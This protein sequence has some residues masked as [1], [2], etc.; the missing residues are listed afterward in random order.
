[1]ACH[2]DMPVLAVPDNYVKSPACIV[3]CMPARAILELVSCSSQLA[4]HVQMM[5]SIAEMPML[6]L[7]AYLICSLWSSLRTCYAHHGA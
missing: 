6:V 3:M 1:M 5:Y 2:T 4:L 7:T